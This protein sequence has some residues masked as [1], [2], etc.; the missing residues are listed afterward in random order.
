[1][2]N[3]IIILLVLTSTQVVGQYKQNKETNVPGIIG[4]SALPTS[5]IVSEIN[6]ANFVGRFGDRD[7]Y[8]QGSKLRSYEDMM[9]QNSNIILTGAIVTGVGLLIQH[10]ISNKRNRSTRKSCWR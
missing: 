8:M 5:F 1:M 10:H 4:L 2:K 6:Y 3:I 7:A 9:R